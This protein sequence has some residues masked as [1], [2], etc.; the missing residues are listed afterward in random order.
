MGS[1]PL[2]TLHQHGGAYGATAE[3]LL[4]Q[5]YDRLKRLAGSY[6]KGERRDHTLSPTAVVHEAYLRL[7]EQRS[8]DWQGRTHFFAVG[9][10]M[11]RRVLVD[12]AR[13]RQRVKRGGEWLRVTLD[14]GADLAWR[15]GG[16]EPE[17]ILSLDAALARLEE[18]DPRQARVVELRFFAGLKV[19]EAASVLDISTRTVEGEWAHAKAWLRRE[20]G[21]AGPR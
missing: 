6:L 9:A 12:H 20:L 8:V 2:L 21:G 4:P 10:R 5:V 17:E 3:E 19:D 16:L 13:G 11:M 18:L 7:A 15:S 1:D 14:G